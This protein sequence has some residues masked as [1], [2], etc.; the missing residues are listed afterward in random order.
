MDSSGQN[1]LKDVNHIGKSIA[2]LDPSHVPATANS[3]R[4]LE[5]GKGILSKEKAKAHDMHFPS[6]QNAKRLCR[7]QVSGEFCQNSVVQKIV[8]TDHSGQSG[9]SFVPSHFEEIDDVSTESDES[10][11]ENYKKDGVD[12]TRNLIHMVKGHEKAVSSSH[13]HDVDFLAMKENIVDGCGNL[14]QEL[15]D[16]IGLGEPCSCSFC[17]KGESYD[18][19]K[20]T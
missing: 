1:I 4:L 14:T 18:N 12:D 3:E 19:L 2:P 8:E 20:L 6:T 15:L 13:D 11:E 9:L 7:P 5:E 16:S 17:L 10:L